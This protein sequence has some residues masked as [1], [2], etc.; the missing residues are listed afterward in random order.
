MNGTVIEDAI[1]CNWATGMLIPLVNINIA[2][3]CKIGPL[4]DQIAPFKL[5]CDAIPSA[6]G[7]I[8]ERVKQK[9]ILTDFS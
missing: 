7:V 3:P 4:A 9:E 5:A 2:C 6:E 1:I 8:C